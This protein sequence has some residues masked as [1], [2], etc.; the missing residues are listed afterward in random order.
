M[1]LLRLY[2]FLKMIEDNRKEGK[3]ILEQSQLVMLR[4]LRIVDEICINNS[5]DYWID[6][7]TLLGAVRHDGFIPWDD[8]LDICMPRKD[9]NKFIELA[10]SEL[11]S[12]TFLQN[13]DTDPTFP[14]YYVKLRDNN[15]T[16][17]ERF[18]NDRNIEFH[19]GIFIDIFPVDFVDDVNEFLLYKRL[20][21]KDYKHKQTTSK[22]LKVKA[23]LKKYF[24][25]VKVKIVGKDSLIST[26]N[27]KYINSDGKYVIKGIELDFESVIEKDKVY[28][29]KRIKFCNFNFLAPKDTH[30]YLK[31]MYGDYMKLPDVSERVSHAFEL[32]PF[33]QCNK[34]KN[35]KHIE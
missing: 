28:P 31:N 8:D 4:L 21:N 26:I 5:L 3:T 10:S 6:S 23:Y 1:I 9:Y 18:E 33:E 11:P 17:I 32:R 35:E 7:G 29:L 27:K 19:Q 13:K 30:T 14:P 34:I 2:L 20:V 12:D 15:S 25:E 22:K 24:A 16:I